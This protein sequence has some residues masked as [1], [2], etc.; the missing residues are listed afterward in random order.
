M[1]FSLC[2][3]VNPAV[4]DFLL[5][6]KY[7][8]DQNQYQYKIKRKKKKIYQESVIYPSDFIDVFIFFVIQPL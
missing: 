2:K 1:E 4:E 5:V 8:L 7:K 6:L 3:K